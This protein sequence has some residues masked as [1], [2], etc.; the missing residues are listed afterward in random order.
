[1]TTPAAAAAT[2]NRT[3]KVTSANGNT[4]AENKKRGTR[5]FPPFYATNP[6]AACVLESVQATLLCHLLNTTAR[7]W[8]WIC[9]LKTQNCWKSCKCSP[10]H[11]LFAFS[12]PTFPP[13]SPQ[14]L[15]MWLQRV[16]FMVK[17]TKKCASLAQEISFSAPNSCSLPWVVKVATELCTSKK[18]Q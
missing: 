4:G 18:V 8:G 16:K 17:K 3:A 10:L 5:R 6:V 14:V 2:G 13:D 7:T 1:M 12:V 11:L 9:H 15:S